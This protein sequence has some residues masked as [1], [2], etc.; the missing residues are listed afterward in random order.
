MTRQ[1]GGA[2]AGGVELLE[3]A[4]SYA[5]SSLHLVT[6]EALTQPT[7]CR[8]WDL[9]TLLAHFDDSLAAINEA[10]EVGHVE[11]EPVPRGRAP[12][13][14]FLGSGVEMDPA[15]PVAQLRNRACRLLG[16]W[17]NSDD[18]DVVAVGALRL[19]TGIVT[20]TGALEVA[21]HGWDV[22]TTCGAMRPIPPG[23]AHELF[24]IA[25]LIV[26]DADRPMR[27][28][29]PLDVGPRADLG[30]R[31]LGFLGRRAC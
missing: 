23:L 19:T 6:Y 7:P 14:G 20:T 10:V 8:G 31:L 12:S 3:R 29:P 9:R 4:I 16:A 25:P 11:L 18:F 1:D 30:A 28:A 26:T 21:V 27:F 2:L 13:G 22:A 5:L 15:D 17:T 24:Q